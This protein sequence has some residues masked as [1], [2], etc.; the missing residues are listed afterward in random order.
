MIHE[1]GHAQGIGS[2]WGRQGLL[3]DLGATPTSPAPVPRRYFDLAGGWNYRGEKVPVQISGGHWREAAFG[4]EI[5]SP[6]SD[7]GDYQAVFNP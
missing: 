5:M 7:Y 3:Q 4:D 2:F 1:L 6:Y